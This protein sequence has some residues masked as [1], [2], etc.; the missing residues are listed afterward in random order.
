MLLKALFLLEDQPHT[1]SIDVFLLFSIWESVKA[2][3]L[4]YI[5][6]LDHTYAQEKK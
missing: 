4:S 1:L 5:P 6:R 2:A 3:I